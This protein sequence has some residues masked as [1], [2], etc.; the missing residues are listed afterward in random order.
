MRCAAT[1]SSAAVCGSA[2]V[3]EASMSA[4]TLSF[5]YWLQLNTPP[6]SSGSM[7]SEG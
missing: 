1:N 7:N 2:A 3:R 6:R 5:E 4:V